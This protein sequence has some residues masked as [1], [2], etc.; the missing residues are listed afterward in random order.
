MGCGCNPLGGGGSA[1]AGAA[2]VDIFNDATVVPSDAEPSTDGPDHL[3]S[4]VAGAP[5]YPPGALM[6]VTGFCVSTSDGTP[7]LVRAGFSIQYSFDSGA[8]WLNT[9]GAGAAVYTAI[10]DVTP[11]FNLAMPG[12]AIDVSAQAQV[13]FRLMLFNGVTAAAP[14]HFTFLRASWVYSGV[15]A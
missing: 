8:T 14:A 3:A 9:N 4:A 15:N 11:A 1:S 13:R 6:I 7:G 5:V 10:D 12:A 2:N